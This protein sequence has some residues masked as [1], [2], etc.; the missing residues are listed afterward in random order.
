MHLNSQLLFRRYCLDYLKP[1]SVV[2]E[3]GAAG[4]SRF[5]RMA[6]SFHDWHTL[7]LCD[8]KNNIDEGLPGHIITEDAYNY[9]VEDSSYDIVLSGQVIEHVPKIWDWMKELRRITRKE[10]YIITIN[11]VSWTYHEDPVDCWRIYPD[12]MEALADSCGLEL[13]FSSFEC[14]E[15]EHLGLDPGKSSIPGFTVPGKTMSDSEGRIF[16]FNRQKYRYNAVLC[17][18]PF[19]RRFLSPIQIPFDT[20]SIMRVPE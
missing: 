11:P 6:G 14:L 15:W 20:I 2:L 18:I 17:R 13:V 8:S 9:P 5:K 7:E 16:P 12:G 1:T 4:G 10:G 3:V 19:L